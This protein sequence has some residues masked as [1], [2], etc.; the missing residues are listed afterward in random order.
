MGFQNGSLVRMHRHHEPF[1]TVVLNIVGFI[2]YF[3][4]F[5]GLSKTYLTLLVIKSSLIK[6][7]SMG[8]ILI[9]SDTFFEI[10]TLKCENERNGITS[11]VDCFLGVDCH[12]M[13]AILL[14]IKV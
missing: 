4:L 12:S 2:S 10:N 13:V 1:L 14:H 6:I 8:S 7:A 5:F 9:W 11:K 3:G